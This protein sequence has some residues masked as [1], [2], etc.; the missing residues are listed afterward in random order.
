MVGR[1]VVHR[2]QQEG[3]D[4]SYIPVKAGTQTGVAIVGV[5]PPDRFPL[6][7]YR[8]NPADIHLSIDDAKFLPIATCRTV[9]LSGT[10]LARGTCRDVIY[11][12][13]VEA[14]RQQ[15][16]VLMDLDFRR[17][18]WSHPAAFG[19]AIE[20]ILANLDVVIGTEEEF[21][22]VWGSD[23]DTISSGSAITDAQRGEI[24]AAIT[25]H[26]A[27]HS[28]PRLF[29]VKRGARGVSLLSRDCDAL[30][31]PAFKVDVVNT[32]GAGD[33]FA[34]G[35]LYGCVHG[36]SWTDC[37]KLGNA[38]GAIV[39]TRNGCSKALPYETEALEFLAASA[40]PLWGQMLETK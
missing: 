38:C 10:A 19:L 1:L 20:S 26:V 34:S 31:V 9:L 21:Y 30:L 16:T 23:F 2:L 28:N 29:M 18:Q 8:L 39:V 6:A 11:Y 14:R 5:Q 22:A 24:D 7:F 37:A 3:V 25:L 12:A 17:D 27:E 15:C 4:T 35:V 40:G 32:V 33:A 13:A 36:W